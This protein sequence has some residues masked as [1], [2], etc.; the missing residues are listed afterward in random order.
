[1]IDQIEIYSKPGCAACNALKGLIE[2]KYTDAIET[3]VYYTIGEDVTVD[4]LTERLG[5]RPRAVPQVFIDGEHV[6]G[7]SKTL[8]KLMNLNS[9]A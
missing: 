1:M 3:I 4:N 9:R 2:E 7:Y 8:E 5:Y 6:G